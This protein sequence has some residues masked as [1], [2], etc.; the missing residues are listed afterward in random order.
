MFAFRTCSNRSGG[1][2]VLELS[3]RRPGALLCIRSVFKHRPSS[4]LQPPKQEVN[5]R[6]HLFE[7]KIM[8]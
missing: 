6:Q 2:N 8:Q 4:S 1:H 3:Q 7:I 5:R